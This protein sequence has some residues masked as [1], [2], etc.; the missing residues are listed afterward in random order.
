[1]T[2][3]NGRRKRTAPIPKPLILITLFGVAMCYMMAQM[4]FWFAPVKQD[5]NGR[6]VTVAIPATPM[7]IHDRAAVSSKPAMPIK[8]LSIIGERNSGTRWTFAHLTECFNGTGITV[9]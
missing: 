7:D 3:N 4:H 1:M 5:F 9:R 6:S 8:E 2:L